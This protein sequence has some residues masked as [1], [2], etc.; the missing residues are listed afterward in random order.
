MKDHIPNAVDRWQ[1]N[2]RKNYSISKLQIQSLIEET[3]KK[4]GNGSVLPEN[5]LFLIHIL[6]FKSI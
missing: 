3:T 4:G 1:N 2:R 5:Q 6:I